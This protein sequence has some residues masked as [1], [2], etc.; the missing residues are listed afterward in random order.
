M[1]AKKLS[2]HVTLR[3]KL[4]VTSVEFNRVSCD[5][6]VRG[7]VVYGETVFRDIPILTL[8]IYKEM[9]E[10]KFQEIWY[11]A[12]IPRLEAIAAFRE[13][14]HDALNEF[15]EPLASLDGEG[16]SLLCRGIHCYL[17][18]LD[19]FHP[20]ISLIRSLRHIAN[21]LRENSLYDWSRAGRAL[22]ALD[23]VPAVDVK[24][25]VED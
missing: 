9:R 1:D 24:L 8:R 25:I 21:S 6:V 4:A 5:V 11:T 22:Y 2:D 14:L 10:V 20:G 23:V 19:G 13:K 3:G 17:E 7:T 12:R 15:W 16:E 18:R